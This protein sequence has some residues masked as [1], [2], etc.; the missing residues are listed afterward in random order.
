MQHTVSLF[1]L[2]GSLEK[3]PYPKNRLCELQAELYKHDVV[4]ALSTI[5][6]F[7]HKSGFSCQKMVMIAKQRDEYLRTVFTLDVSV[8][9]P[10][11][12]VFLNETGADQRNAK[13]KYVY[14]LRGK[15]ARS[16]KRFIRGEHISA[17][18]VMSSEGL[19]DCKV[20]EGSVNGNEFYIFVHTHLIP[21]LQPFNGRNPYRVVFLNNASIH[22]IEDVVKAI[23]DV[24]GIV[25][26]FPPYLPDLNPIEEL[27]SK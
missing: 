15:P 14:S 8:Y 23:E 27:F 13:R 16:H 21:H 11:I 20:V 9:K 4:V 26:F 7:L 25:H 10:E 12:L 24:G 18:A 22:H 2:T 6:D 1:E 17:I 19:L 5:W 3:R